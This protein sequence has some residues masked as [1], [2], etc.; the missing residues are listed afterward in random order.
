VES[1]DG[2][3]YGCGLHITDIDGSMHV[4]HGGSMVGHASMML[5]DLDEG[6]GVVVMI[7]GNDHPDLTLQIS[8]Y[9]LS[10]VR[11]TR[12]GDRLPSP[13][14][15]VDPSRWRTPPTTRGR[16]TGPTD[17]SL[18]RRKEG[19]CSSRLRA[20]AS[21]SSAEGLSRD[22]PPIGSGPIIHRSSCSSCAFVVTG[23]RSPS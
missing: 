1:E 20:I 22:P 12:R 7:N 23:T 8:K 19:G 13:P 2:I 5:A 11:A 14:A 16:T 3:F 17:R 18:S 4:G 6:I 21:R 15:A 9:A 10:L